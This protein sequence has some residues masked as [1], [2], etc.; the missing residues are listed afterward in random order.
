ML[1]FTQISENIQ[2]ALFDRIDALNRDRNFAP[3]SPQADKQSSMDKI[4]TR[5][6]WASVTSAIYDIDQDGNL[7]DGSGPDKIKKLFQISSGIDKNS[8]PINEPI[9]TK[10]NFNKPNKDDMHR[11]HSGVTSISTSFKSHSIQDVTINWKFWDIKDF[12]RYKEAFLKHGRVVLVEFGWASNNIT[13]VKNQEVKTAGDLLTIF[14]S[15]QKQIKE[16]GGDY[17]CAMGRIKNYSYTINPNGGFDCTTTLT[18]MGSSLFKGQIDPVTAKKVPEIIVENNSDKTA[19]ALQGSN[20]YFEKFMENLDSNIEKA[21]NEGAGTKGVYHDG[22]KGWCNWAWFEDIVLNTFFS[23]TTESGTS[24]TG[25]LTIDDKTA[26]TLLTT[27]VRSCDTLFDLDKKSKVTDTFVE[28]TKC[29][30]SKDLYTNGI[31]II[32]PGQTIGILDDKDSVML[33]MKDTY[34]SEIIEE[35]QKLFKVFTDMNDPDIMPPFSTEFED[36]EGFETFTDEEAAKPLYEIGKKGIIRNM[37]FSSDFLK[38]SFGEGVVDLGSAITSHWEAVSSNYGWYWSFDVV[39]S[40]NGNGQIGVIDRHCTK[41]RVEEVNPA[42]QFGKKS[43]RDD[44]TG[45]FVF[46]NYGKNSLMKDFSM[47]VKLSAAQATMAVY[48]TNKNPKRKDG[49]TNKPEDVGVATLA[50]LQNINIATTQSGSDQGGKED[51]V[52]DKITYPYMENKSM[53]YINTRDQDEGLI[54]GGVDIAETTRVQP[55]GDTSSA[56]IVSELDTINLNEERIEAGE[57]YLTFN[58]SAEDPKNVGLVF[59]PEGELIPGYNRYML[60]FLTK[61]PQSRADYDP[62]VP[63]TVSFSIPGIGGISLYDM[64]SIDYLPETYK[65]FVVFQATTV[66]HTLDTTGWTTSITG[67][68]RVDTIKLDVGKKTDEDVKKVVGT[69]ETSLNFIQAKIDSKKK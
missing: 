67:Q 49:G 24:T 34:S 18:S 25:D 30:N 20:F 5:S 29:R 44:P 35:Y 37:V 45:T 12:E 64:F 8:Q 53:A 7:L 2:K 4:L 51:V 11:G 15:T 66:D 63:F 40:N 43:T 21:Y 27:K 31:N 68:M 48:H 39:N 13:T 14:N 54:P 33:Q 59:T 55:F 3:L 23:W 46:S 47:D 61:T 69:I 50:E 58:K 17:Y 57:V 16:A 60:Y 10:N 22:K 19:E 1:Q 38:Q 65:E 9:T 26:N 56:D 6:T 41:F 42:G 62:L 36:T 28:N 52:I 32:L